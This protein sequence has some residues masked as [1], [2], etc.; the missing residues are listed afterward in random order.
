MHDPISGD[1]IRRAGRVGGDMGAEQQA[2][3]KK[4]ES[5]FDNV[6]NDKAKEM[7]ETK[8]VLQNDFNTQVDKMPEA[9]KVEIQREWAT[10][11]S[12]MERADQTEFFARKIEGSHEKLIQLEKNLPAIDD[13]PW[14]DMMVN[15]LDEFQTEYSQLDSFLKDFSAG[16]EFNQQELLAV[17][18]RAHQVTQSVEILSKAVEH[19]ISG[20]KTIFQTNV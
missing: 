18:I 9:Q 19:S 8:N 7:E 5:K 12:Q 13:G 3:A 4:G 11:V 6:M 2:P 15:R 10:R 20:M 14:K 1:A 16:K 17:Q